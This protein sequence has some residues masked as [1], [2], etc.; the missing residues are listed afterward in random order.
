MSDVKSRFYDVTKQNHEL[1]LERQALDLKLSHTQQILS[2]A[3]QASF[4][5]FVTS[6]T[7]AIVLGFGVNVVTSTPSD[8]KGWVIVASSVVLGVIAFFIPRKEA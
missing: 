1:E 7:A 5:K 3:S 8:W 2:E 4:T 6:A